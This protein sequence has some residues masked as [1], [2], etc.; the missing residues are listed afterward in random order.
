MG[1]W[2]REYERGEERD[3]ERRD[4]KGGSVRVE[5]NKNITK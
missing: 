3:G 2:E 1:G 5:T 4:R